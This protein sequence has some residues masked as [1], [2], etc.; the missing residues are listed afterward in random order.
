MKVIIIAAIVV[1]VLVVIFAAFYIW[2]ML[3]DFP[4]GNEARKREFWD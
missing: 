1:I 2:S 3:K 4:K